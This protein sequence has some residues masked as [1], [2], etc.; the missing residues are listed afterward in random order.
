MYHSLLIPSPAE[1]WSLP[2]SAPTG[3]PDQP[4]HWEEMGMIQPCTSA[5]V[6][7]IPRWYFA[8]PRNSKRLDLT[9]SPWN[10]WWPWGGGRD[11]CQDTWNKHMPGWTLQMLSTY[12]GT[13]HMTCSI[14]GIPIG[15][16]ANTCMVTYSSYLL[17]QVFY[18]LRYK[19]WFGGPRL[20]P[21]GR[22]GMGSQHPAPLHSL[23]N[24]PSRAR[25]GHST[26][27]W[28]CSLSRE[29]GD[30]DSAKHFSWKMS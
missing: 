20:K 23:R 22:L 5:S 1:S 17:L 27:S 29:S 12:W 24:L 15:W 13:C 26:H 16:S 2:I 28:K 30:Y 4:T 14:S 11:Q 6:S 3:V 7:P 18:D 21:S 10:N 8:C 19:C 9:Y 25:C